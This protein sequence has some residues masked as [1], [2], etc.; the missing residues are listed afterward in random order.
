MSEEKNEATSSQSK[1][2]RQRARK[3]AAQAAHAEA[4]KA[5]QKKTTLI[6]VAVIAI[7]G[8]LIAGAYF[9]MKK[10]NDPTLG[11]APISIEGEALPQP[12]QPAQDATAQSLFSSDT[13]VGKTVPTIKGKGFDGQEH[14]IGK[15]AGKPQAIAVVAHWC[16]YCQDEVKGAKNW[17]TD[18]TVPEG[19]ELI[20]LTTQNSPQRP[21]WPADKWF[22]T[23]QWPGLSLYD[24][25]TDDGKS[26]GSEALGIASFPTWIF[27]DA[28]GKVVGRVS[29]AIG[30]ETFKEFANTTLEASKSK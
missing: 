24:T 5:E 16:H 29:G 30:A 4:Q 21:N 11:F 22:E 28:D 19:I 8:V 12:G 26:P 25:P 6:V 2:D 17:K 1:R 14:I 15:G 18:G 27:T 23:E 7:V 3:A 9:M 10:S 20:A 13:A